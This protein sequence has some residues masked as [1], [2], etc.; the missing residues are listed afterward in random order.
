MKKILFVPAYS[1]LAIMMLGIAFITFVT[2]DYW[3]NPSS[4]TGFEWVTPLLYLIAGIVV[5]VG[6]LLAVIAGLIAKLKIFQRYLL[7]M[8]GLYLIF[9]CA[10]VYFFWNRS[11][12]SASVIDDIW[13]LILWS[14]LFVVPVLVSVTGSLLIRRSSP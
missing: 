5:T 3:L 1:G 6:A 8:S 12:E 11:I 9:Y 14:V 2:I 10:I 4:S 7:F 13:S